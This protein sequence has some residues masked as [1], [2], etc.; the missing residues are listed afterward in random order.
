MYET[1]PLRRDKNNYT[2]R[3]VGGNG[4]EARL[5][6]LKGKLCQYV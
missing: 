5:K 3:F 4:A 2:G 1:V 6:L